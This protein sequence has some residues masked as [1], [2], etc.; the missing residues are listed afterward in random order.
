MKEIK[1]SSDQKV[2]FYHIYFMSLVLNTHLVN[3]KSIM[4]IV[5]RFSINALNRVSKS[6]HNPKL[7][8]YKTWNTILNGTLRE[9]CIEIDLF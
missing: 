8:R 7:I 1:N 3:A 5:C 9:G 6:H 4:D 2:N